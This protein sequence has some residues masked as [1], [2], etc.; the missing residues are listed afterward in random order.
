MA[1]DNKEN[2]LLWRRSLSIRVGR[3]RHEIATAEAAQ[4]QSSN[5][6]N[7]A[8]Q[9]QPQA[10]VDYYQQQQQQPATFGQTMVSYLVSGLAIGFGISLIRVIF[11]EPKDD[12]GGD[13]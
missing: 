12:D 7:N 4:Q 8:V 6:S 11:S 3:K 10:P 13:A 2:A 9:P 5:S 1:I